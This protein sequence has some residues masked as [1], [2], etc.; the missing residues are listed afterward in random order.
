[1]IKISDLRKNF[2]KLE[3]LKGIDLEIEDGRIYG[4]IGPNASG[5]TTLIK[6]I[7]GLIKPESGNIIVDEHTIN[8]DYRY[9][10]N[11]GYMPQKAQ[12]PENLTVKEILRL[13][14]DLRNYPEQTDDD[15]IATFKL[16]KEM[17]KA[18]KN[19]SGGTRQKVSAV[20]SFLFRPKTLILDEPT[21]GLDPVASGSL[22]DKILQE[23]ENGK[24]FIITSH[25]ISEIEE[26]ADQ[27]IFL[28]EG[29]VYFQGSKEMVHA[30]TQEKNLERAIA[31]LMENI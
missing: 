18:L 25:I 1:M 4:I 31:T 21:A 14:R 9:R 12:F 3:V 2:G 5:K 11:L 30:H 26:L 20:I 29:A 27:I 16:E 10:G 28:L 22:K 19:L 24:T 6:S 8:G 13:V 17:N 15:L 7:L 23:K